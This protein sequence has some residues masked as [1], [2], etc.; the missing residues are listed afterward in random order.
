MSYQEQPER[1]RRASFGTVTGE[2]TGTLLGKVF[3]LLAFSLAFAAVGG[4]VGSQLGSSWML[5]LIIVEFGLIFAVQGLRNREGINFVLLYA[6]AF[7][8]GMTLGPILAAYVSAGM[9]TVV[10]EAAGTTGAMTVGLSIYALG[11]KRDLSGL[12]PYLFMGLIGLVG[13]MLLNMFV[14]GSALSGVLSW[15]G[16]LLFSVLLVFEVNRIR[17]VPD[18]MGNAVVITLS[19]YL[20]ILNLFL[21]LL[22]IFGGGSRR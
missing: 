15:G 13:A 17:Y 3:G 22:R 7:V 19:I 8:S 4:L 9:G 18:T 10:L 14:G 11:T 6:F 2:L 21:F 1:V 20:D 16:A 12:Q 5:P